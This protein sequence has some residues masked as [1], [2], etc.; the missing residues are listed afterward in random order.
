MNKRKKNFRFNPSEGIFSPP[1]SMVSFGHI[2]MTGMLE[3]PLTSVRIPFIEVG[4]MACQN[5]IPSIR[6][7]T[8]QSKDPVLPVEFIVRKT[9]KPIK[10]R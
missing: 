8:L 7:R 2:P 9:T 6:G 4:Q 5:L 3:T 10:E 1:I